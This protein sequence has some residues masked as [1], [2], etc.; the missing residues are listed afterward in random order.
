MIL[1]STENRFDDYF[2]YFRRRDDK[3]DG[4]INMTT[5]NGYLPSMHNDIFFTKNKLDLTVE[6]DESIDESVGELERERNISVSKLEV[7]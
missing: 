5:L 3:N 1:R 7:S 4:V 2:S 6:R